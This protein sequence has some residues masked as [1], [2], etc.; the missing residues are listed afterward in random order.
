MRAYE[1]VLKQSS[2]FI[3]AAVIAFSAVCAVWL[4]SPVSL[5]QQARSERR[6]EKFRTGERVRI[7]LEKGGRTV[8]IDDVKGCFKLTLVPDSVL[9]T[10][11]FH[12]KDARC[13]EI[14]EAKIIKVDRYLNCWYF[15]PIE[16]GHGL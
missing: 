9:N 15:E 11:F 10:G 4:F 5:D 7:C 6:L 3:L 1:K 13:A 12:D 16:I 2:K 8:K 14:I